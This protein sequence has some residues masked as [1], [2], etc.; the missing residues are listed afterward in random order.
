MLRLAGFGT[1]TWIRPHSR[2][3]TAIDHYSCAMNASKS[4]KLRNTSKI[5]KSAWE[6][7]NGGAHDG[8]CLV[9]RMPCLRRTFNAKPTCEAHPF[10]ICIDSWNSDVSLVI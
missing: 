9:K 4:L 7:W 1:V 2:A 5:H 8:Q 3:G 10:H 6:K